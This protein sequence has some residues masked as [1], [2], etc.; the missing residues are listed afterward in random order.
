[1][2]VTYLRNS[3]T[4][5]FEK[6]GPGGATTDTTLS[7]AGK[8]A[9]AAAVGSA[10]TSYA[11]KTDVP[12]FVAQT[13]IKTDPL[14][15]ETTKIQ[16]PITEDMAEKL[17]NA[18]QILMH[19]YLYTCAE[20]EAT[21]QGTVTSGILYNYS[22]ST[23]Y[24]L[25]FTKELQCVPIPAISYSQYSNVYTIF[26]K[27]FYDESVAEHTSMAE[28]IHTPIA[29]RKNQPTVTQTVQCGVY[30]VVGGHDC[31]CIETSVP[32]G[33]GSYVELQV[34]GSIV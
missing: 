1:M 27:G 9:D 29:S 21:T 17:N 4:G 6:V 10:L 25:Q 28:I 31:L 34:R 8:P 33:V 13:I 26:E 3:E 2:A 24:K 23:Y 11:L 5:Q 7:Q 14:T 32:M 30:T 15:E 20:N 22:S 12:S 18:F 19:I 16:I